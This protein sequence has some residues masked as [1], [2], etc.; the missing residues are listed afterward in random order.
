MLG[1]SFVEFV[2]GSGA[3]IPKG[4]D[5]DQKGAKMLEIVYC[6]LYG[7][8]TTERQEAAESNVCIRNGK[9][10]SNEQV[11]KAVG[12]DSKE[13]REVQNDLDM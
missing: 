13:R 2:E 8:A 12:F 9:R 5:V 4:M 1:R 11:L 7:V 10:Y 3:E 6:D